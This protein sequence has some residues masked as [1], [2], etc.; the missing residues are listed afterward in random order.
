MRRSLAHLL[1]PAVN[2][3]DTN[4]ERRRG[5]SLLLQG[6][7]VLFPGCIQ[8]M[9]IDGITERREAQPLLMWAASLQERRWKRHSLRGITTFPR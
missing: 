8:I 6:F 3:R 2:N 4:K 9:V 5:Y 1:H 7:R